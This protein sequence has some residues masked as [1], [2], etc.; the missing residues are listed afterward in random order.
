VRSPLATALTDNLLGAFGLTDNAEEPVQG[1]DA[2][3]AN[4]SHN[5]GEKAQR[6]FFASEFM[7]LLCV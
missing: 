7:A 2:E 6:S 5:R 3:P 4:A 1:L